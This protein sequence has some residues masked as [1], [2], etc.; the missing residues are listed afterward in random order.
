MSKQTQNKKAGL[1]YRLSQEDE[2]AGESLSIE[3][4]KKI[5]EKYA[6]E[7]GFEIV[8]EYIDDGWS[9][10]NFNRPGVQRLLEDAKNGRINVIIVKDLSRFGRNY[11]EVGQYTDYLFP[12][13]NIRFIAVGDNVDSATTENTGM[14][15]TPIMNVFNEWHAANTSKKIKAV[16]EANAKE[17]IYRCSYAPY[18][19]IK[20]DD[21]KRLPVVDSEAAANVRRIFEMRASGVSPNHIAQTFNDEGIL[22]PADYKEAK[23]GIPNTRKTHHLW[24]VTA[25]KQIVTNPTYL[26]HLVQMRTTNVS[27]KNKKQIKRD[28][29]DMVWVYN[30]HEAIVS[31]ELWDKCREM[32]AS[33]SQGK[34]NKTGYVNPL[35][36][37]VYCAD[38]G[39]K[40]YI[41]YNNTRHKRGGER[42]YYRQNFTCGTYSKFGDRVCTSHY[43]KIDVLK[44][45]VLADIRFRMSLVLEDEKRAREEFLRRN[46][47]QNTAEINAD[48]RK[49]VQSTRRLAELDK[50][51]GSVYEDKVLG[52]IPEEVCINLLKKYQ[53]EKNTLTET[54]TTLERKAQDIRDD[55]ANADEFIRR[56]KA[57][58]EVPELTREM[59]MELIEFITVDECPGKYSKAPRE[60]HI[61]YKLIDK[62]SSA[63]QIAVWK[64]NEND[65]V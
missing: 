55:A 56:L 7:N 15:M 52:K 43:I 64:T 61:Y 39:N 45:L 40:M 33:V 14:D 35:S 49:L 58:M 9:G 23:F 62:K 51:I 36:G 30:T 11:I 29:E 53:A 48:K 34:K 20:G 59:C 50:L 13:Y 17:G 4:Q 26:G 24:S 3:N 21:E 16:I 47:Q 38:C 8:D 46:E 18:G 2:R 42:I 44:E 19:Y 25:I 27:Y 28:P 6:H 1:Y 12:T 10:T 31:Q 54:V 60:I 5:L 41:K 63:E 37:L 65:N 32:E 22:P 57:Y